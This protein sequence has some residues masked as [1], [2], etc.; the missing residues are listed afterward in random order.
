MNKQNLD[1]I[2]Y[3]T[4]EILEVR[5]GT[6]RAAKIFDI[7]YLLTIILNLAA[8]IMYTYEKYRLQYGPALMLIENITVAMFCA[9]YILRL[10]AASERV[11][12]RAEVYPVLY[13]N[14]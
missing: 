1:H 2:R 9:D 10:F 3:R 6:D 4:Y 8:S 7:G 5:S 12:C 14:Y 13:R 11:P